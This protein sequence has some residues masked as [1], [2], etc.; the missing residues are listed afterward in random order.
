MPAHNGGAK[1]DRRGLRSVP[2]LQVVGKKDRSLNVLG[3]VLKRN[4]CSPRAARAAYHL[5]VELDN[6]GFT[7]ETFFEGLA[8]LEK[9]AEEEKKHE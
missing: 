6:A 7:K 1:K 9:W 2:S 4:G 3:E 8:L 5:I